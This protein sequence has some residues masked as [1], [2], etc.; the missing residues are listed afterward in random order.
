MN[1][2]SI[3]SRTLKAGDIFI[4]LDGRN[5][6][7]HKFVNNAF[8]R[9]AFYAIVSKD[10]NDFVEQYNVT[11]VGNTILALQ[12]LAQKHLINKNLVC[13]G[14]TGS[15]GKTTTKEIVATIL[16]NCFSLEDI[17]ATFKNQNSDIGLPL[18]ALKINIKH[19][20]GI[21]EMGISAPGE[22]EVMLKIINPTVGL[23]T[24]I[25][26]SHIGNF[27][28]L[29]QI[30]KEKGTLF[31]VLPRSGI[32][33]ININNEFCIHQ[34]RLKLIAGLFFFGRQPWADLR[35][36]S[37]SPLKLKYSSEVSIVK[38][39]LPGLHNMQNAIAAVA[40]ALAIGCNFNKT[41]QALEK[42]TPIDSRLKSDILFNNVILL[43]DTYNASPDSVRAAI[44]YL[45]SFVSIQ[46]FI[47]LGG[48]YELGGFARSEHY[49]IGFFCGSINI[50]AI[51]VC[52]EYAIDYIQG[53]LDAGF[54]NEKVH[55]VY[56]VKDILVFLISKIEHSTILLIKG[57]RFVQMEIII[58]LIKDLKLR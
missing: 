46:K 9:G 30:K 7:G 15:V 29:S 19:K 28:N 8:V 12:Y 53:V 1:C 58:S 50:D 35:I 33:I 24:N 16:R 57:S 49:N 34:A 14:I 22:L 4:A 42:A 20:I 44:L 18:C 25:G 13:I 37:V 21:F 39:N 55:Y 38:L 31:K 6:N 23:I 56:S 5:A 47:I 32:G 45:D 27:K 2:Y 36:I 17:Y 51:F 41:L 26:I 10:F 11:K 40:T 48:M 43:D 3:D 52:G 54:S